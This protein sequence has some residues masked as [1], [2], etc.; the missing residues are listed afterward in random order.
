MGTS[1]EANNIIYINSL[2][3][4]TPNLTEA[5]YRSWRLEGGLGP[6][7]VLRTAAARSGNTGPLLLDPFHRSNPFRHAY[8]PQ[9]GTGAAITRAL[10]ITFDEE[11][12]AGSLAGT[13]SETVSGLIGGDLIARGRIRLQ[14]ISEQGVLQ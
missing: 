1:T 3:A 8:H 9:H 11:Q 7:A 6:D 10:T 13:Y 14:R 4:R 2:Q 5:Y 12:E